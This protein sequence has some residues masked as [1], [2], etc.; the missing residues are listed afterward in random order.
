M[1]KKATRAA[2]NCPR[3]GAPLTYNWRTDVLVCWSRT[4]T[5]MAPDENDL[6]PRDALGRHEPRL[7]EER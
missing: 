3:C 2:H 1:R 4:C 6:P 5:Y 7:N